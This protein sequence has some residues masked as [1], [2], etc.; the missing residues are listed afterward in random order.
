MPI[1]FLNNYAENN[2]TNEITQKDG[3]PLQGELWLYRQFLKFNEYNLLPNENWYLKH[4]YN[5]SQHPASKG[6]VEGQIDFILL[7]KKGVL[8]IEIKGGGVEVDENDTY[9]S[10]N[11][12]G[13]YVAQ[14]PFNQAKE[15]THTLKELID[16]KAFIYRAIVFPHEAGFKLEGPQ[17]SGYKDLLFSKNDFL[18]LNDTDDAKEINNRFFKFI[19]E[20][21]PKARRTI[22]QELN[23]SLSLEKVNNRLYEYFPE[24]KSKQLKRLKSELFPTQSTYGYNPDSINNEIILDENYEILK[25]LRRNRKVMVQGA[26]G[27]GKTVL[28][29]KFI[30]ENLLKQHKGIVYCANKLVMSKLKHILTEQYKLDANLI[31]FRIYYEVNID[32]ISNDVDFLVFDESQ[33]YFNKRLYDFI[34]NLELKLS[35]PKFLILYDPNQSIINDF[36]DLTWYTDYFIDNGFTHYLFNE[37]YRCIQNSEINQISQCILQNNLNKKSSTYSKNV[38]SIINEVDK[39][40]M[41]KEIVDENKFTNSE[42]II[43]VHSHLLDSFKKVVN[44]YFKDEIEELS[45]SNINLSSSKIKFSTSL[46][47][48]G[49]ENKSV[50]LITNQ[51]D[52]KSRVQN[53][54]AI[55]RAMEKI[56]IILWEN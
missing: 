36:Q 17:L 25:G 14:N 41:I 42:K 55:T 13:K 47:Y 43:L 11:K 28:A 20:L 31:D 46:K 12:N 53:Y 54:V 4:D 5:L 7:S 35:N 39:I 40:R 9:F 10:Y 38:V 15:Y 29:K 18:N 22:I 32:N 24:I 27:T 1:L 2:L 33:E 37:V 16:S 30:A 6:K 50:Y 21:A 34:E 44:S 26:P 49:L 51:L 3:T 52:E 45:E 23:P 56:K 19:T 48:R 8:I